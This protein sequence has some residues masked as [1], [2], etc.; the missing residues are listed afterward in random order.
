MRRVAVRRVNEWDGPSMLKI[1]GPYTGTPAA[2]EASPPDLQDYVQ[3]ID[4]TPT[5]WGGCC[6]RSTTRPRASAI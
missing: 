2:P 4:R 1:Y 6:A 3:R 5:A